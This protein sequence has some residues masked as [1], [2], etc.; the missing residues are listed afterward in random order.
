MLHVTMFG[1]LTGSIFK[2][3]II[4]SLLKI[5]IYQTDY[6]QGALFIPISVNWMSS[7]EKRNKTCQ[8]SACLNSEKLDLTSLC[9][10][11]FCA[12]CSATKRP[13]FSLWYRGTSQTLQLSS[14]LSCLLSTT[15][16]KLHSKMYSGLILLLMIKLLSC[17]YRPI[18]I[19]DTRFNTSDKFA[20]T[21][22]RT[23]IEHPN[24]QRQQLRNKTELDRAV[25]GF[26]CKISHSHISAEQFPVTGPAGKHAQVLTG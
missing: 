20:D 25:Q 3:E 9:Q 15:L 12:C 17:Y 19:S 10:S 16:V 23:L 21:V 4:S 5:A 6:L 8:T 1:T 7:P 22:D 26:L 14:E 2:S 24:A 13:L 18:T 11:S